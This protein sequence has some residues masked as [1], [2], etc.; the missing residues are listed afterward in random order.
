VVGIG[1]ILD[2]T[3]YWYNSTDCRCYAKKSL[4]RWYIMHVSTHILP[5]EPCEFHVQLP[6]GSYPLYVKVNG[7]KNL[8]CIAEDNLPGAELV[9]Y[10]FTII[11]SN[12][13][14]I[15]DN[16]YL[17]VLDSYINRCN[18]ILHILT[19]EVP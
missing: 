5:D 6:K 17:Y 18:R 8:L 4:G 14:V 19:S 9:D 2:T 15:T 10:K 13:E 12:T 7:N 11:D 16:Y 1:T 3:W